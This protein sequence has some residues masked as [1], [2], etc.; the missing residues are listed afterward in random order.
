MLVERTSTL[1]LRGAAT[2]EASASG[3]Q[4]GLTHTVACQEK[5]ASLNTETGYAQGVV[6]PFGGQSSFQCWFVLFSK[7]E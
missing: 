3:L 1:S 4:V 5:V 6:H 2:E 7:A